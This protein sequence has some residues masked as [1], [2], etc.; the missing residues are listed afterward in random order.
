MAVI[1]VLEFGANKYEPHSWQS[2]DVE[3]FNAAARRHRFAR[4][5][6]EDWDQESGLLHL[7]HE[8]ANLLFQLELKFRKRP[9][10]S[11]TS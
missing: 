11:R 7:A 8:A 5:M 10:Y 2:V 6:G 4:D 9:M 3:H 1:H